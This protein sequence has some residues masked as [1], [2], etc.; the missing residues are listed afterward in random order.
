MKGIYSKINIEKV[1]ALL[2]RCVN[3]QRRECIKCKI[4]WADVQAINTVL[5]ELGLDLGIL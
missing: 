3:C 4:C 2:K 1:A 5:L